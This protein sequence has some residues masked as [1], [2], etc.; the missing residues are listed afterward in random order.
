[1]ARTVSSVGAPNHVV[2]G[3]SSHASARNSRTTL[4]VVAISIPRRSVAHAMMPAVTPTAMS[5]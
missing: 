5:R 3:V 2:C 4:T 1:M